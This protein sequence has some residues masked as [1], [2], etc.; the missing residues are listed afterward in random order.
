LQETE[1]RTI[2]AGPLRQMVNSTRR[3]GEQMR[4][5][6]DM[7][8][9]CGVYALNSV[10]RALKGPAY[11][12]RQISRAPAPATGFS[13]TKLIELARQA[14]VDLIAA[15]W[16]KEK[17]LVVPSVVHWKENHYAAILA[18]RDDNYQ[19][20]DSVLGN[21]PRWLKLADIR[22]EA[23]GQ[24]IVSRDKLPNGWRPLAAAETDHHLDLRCVWPG[25]QQGG[26]PEQ[27]DVHL[28]LRCQQPFD[29]P[30]DAGQGH[31]DVW[32]RCGRQPDQYRVPAQSGHYVA[33]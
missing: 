30:V 5:A 6:T 17:T 4:N 11:D 19:V 18:Q 7:D 8:F 22:E 32:L 10:A 14:G 13:M 15:E 28:R 9:R 3:A 31:H 20:I 26:Q 27:P 2:E 12:P 29:Q 21:N 16:G 24:F 33:V 25:D 1:G 23:T